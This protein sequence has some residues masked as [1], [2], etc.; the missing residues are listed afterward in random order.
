MNNHIPFNSFIASLIVVLMVYLAYAD[1]DR[2][3]Y[4]NFTL[5]A[6][7]TV[8]TLPIDRQAVKDVNDSGFTWSAPESWIPT[9]KDRL[10]FTRSGSYSII[11]NDEV[12]DCSIM[13]L[14][15]TDFNS[16]AVRWARQAGITF[17][18]EDEITAVTQER[19]SLMGPYKMLELINPDAKGKSVLGG[20]YPIKNGSLFVK[21]MG[22]TLALQAVKKQLQIFADSVGVKIEK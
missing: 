14:G 16:N 11:V 21:F 5:P 20:I 17:K 4:K 3:D 6:L 15:T 12:V 2:E 8:E 7:L 10:M 18:T 9:K 13:S 1:D 19:K 22:P